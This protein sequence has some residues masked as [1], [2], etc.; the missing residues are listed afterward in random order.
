MYV[1]HTAPVFLTLP[2]I[3]L[4]YEIKCLPTEQLA[5]VNALCNSSH[6]IANWQMY[7]IMHG[8]LQ[9]HQTAT[10]Q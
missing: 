2:H 5:P 6:Y 1:S 4:Q 7:A 8:T 10:A 9:V 3:L